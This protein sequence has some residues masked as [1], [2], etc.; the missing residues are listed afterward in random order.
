MV[1]SRKTGMSYIFSFA[2]YFC[3]NKHKSKMA[4]KQSNVIITANGKQAENVI[5]AIKQRIDLLKASEE[6]L[7]TK[8]EQM[9]NEGK[10]DTEEYKKMNKALRDV[11][12]EIKSLDSAIEKNVS[13]M[14]LVDKAIKNIATH[15][16]SQLR[17]ALRAG[18]KELEGMSATNKNLEPLRQTKT[19][20]RPNQQKHGCRK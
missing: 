1:D 12:K 10:Q 15:T 4:T 14:E 3:I 8:L 20:S 17:I 18:K 7:K 11:R 2:Y 13:N 9:R 5:A 16:N 19:Y 6:S